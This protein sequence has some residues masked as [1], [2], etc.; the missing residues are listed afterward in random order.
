MPDP[1]RADEL[2]GFLTLMGGGAFIGIGSGAINVEV[3]RRAI[4]VVAGAFLEL[5]GL[6][7]GVYP[8]VVPY[9]PQISRW[10]DRLYRLLPIR[11]NQDRTPG[12]GALFASSVD[13]VNVQAS[14]DLAV[15][16]ADQIKT[17][18]K[19]TATLE[20]D[21][22]ALKAQLATLQHDWPKRLTDVEAS[23]QHALT[24]KFDEYRPLRI[25]GVNHPRPRAG[26]QHVRESYRVR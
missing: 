10:L 8:D 4:L 14:G 9:G 22:S 2:L 15:G 11:R 5:V 19:K 25:S 1:A 21:V 23:S 6:G 20:H 16:L 12:T 3:S 17:L 26:I 13:F 7:F 24:A 18:E